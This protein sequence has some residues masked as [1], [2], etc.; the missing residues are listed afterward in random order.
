MPRAALVEGSLEA[1]LD[2][3]SSPALLGRWSWPWRTSFRVVGPNIGP[4]ACWL[5]MV[6]IDDAVVGGGVVGLGLLAFL[7][8][9]DDDGTC[10]SPDVDDV[11]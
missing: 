8:L 5:L 6:I 10:I 11:A 2:K 4:L 7:A 3:G 9:G 1:L